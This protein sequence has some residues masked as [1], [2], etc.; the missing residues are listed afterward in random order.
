MDA[1]WT[2]S[3][4][5][6]MRRQ[7]AEQQLDLFDSQ[8]FTP[9]LWNRLANEIKAI[10]QSYLQQAIV[11]AGLM[12]QAYEFEIGEPVKVI[13]PNYTRNDL[14]GLLAGDFL[15]RDIDSFTFMR[16]IVSQK[17]QPMKLVLSLADRYPMQYLRTF[18]KTG[19]MEFRTDLADF[20]LNYPGSYQQRIKRVEVIIEGL[21]GHGGIHGM[22]TNTGLC[23]TRVRDGSVKMRLLKPETLLLSNY[24]IGPDSIVFSMD[25]QTLAI[26]ENSPVATSW[27]LE[28]RPRQ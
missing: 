20:D 4:I 8:E 7:Q 18:Q 15:L 9:D 6:T 21:V 19:R 16:T 24:R 5:A 28:L 14:S 17:K 1:A 13:K 23:L 11:I 3:L 22:L 27:I 10:S 12:E 26:F 25:T 2:Q